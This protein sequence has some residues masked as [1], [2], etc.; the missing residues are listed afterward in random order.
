MSPF[1]TRIRLARAMSRAVDGGRDLIALAEILDDLVRCVGVVRDLA[2]ILTLRQDRL[3]ECLAKSA[4][5]HRESSN[6]LR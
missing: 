3:D 5:A 1:E 2:T 4:D 6:W